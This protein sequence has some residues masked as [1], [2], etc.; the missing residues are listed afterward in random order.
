MG[1]KAKCLYTSIWSFCELFVHMLIIQN[2]GVHAY[3]DM[4]LKCKYNYCR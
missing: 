3:Y 2:V 4:C 1:F